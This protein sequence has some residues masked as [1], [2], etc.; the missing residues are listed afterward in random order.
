VTVME[1]RHPLMQRNYL[2][3]CPWCGGLVM[4][5]FN[6]TTRDGKPI[7]RMCQ[8]RS[9]GLVQ[10]RIEHGDSDLLVESDSASGELT[11][12]DGTVRITICGAWAMQAVRDAMYTACS[13]QADHDA[14]QNV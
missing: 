6:C 9:I 13:M 8:R 2:G 5:H 10:W 4:S 7:H 14:K 12:V 1:E 11:L 3:D